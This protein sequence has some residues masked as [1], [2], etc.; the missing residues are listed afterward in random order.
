M[1]VAWESLTPAQAAVAAGCSRV[2]PSGRLPRPLQRFRRDR[3]GTRRVQGARSYTSRWISRATAPPRHRPRDAADSTGASSSLPPS[4]LPGQTAITIGTFTIE[5]PHTTGAAVYSRSP[6]RSVHAT[7]P[8]RRS[9]EPP[10]LGRP[11]SALTTTEIT[12][13]LTRTG[14]RVQRPARTGPPAVR[15]GNRDT[16][17]AAP[18]CNQRPATTKAG[19]TWLRA[20]HASGTFPNTRA[21]CGRVSQPAFAARCLARKG[22]AAMD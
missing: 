13:P 5:I 22:T 9:D 14:K 7:R 11:A 21:R 12:P 17:P 18:S 1:L 19:R 10:W 4:P 20:R 2:A 15:W 3:A 6:A 8:P 16:G